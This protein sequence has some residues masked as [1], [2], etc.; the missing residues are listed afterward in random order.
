MCQ[1]VPKGDTRFYTEEATSEQPESVPII[2]GMVTT[3]GAIL[4]APGPSRSADKESARIAAAFQQA[5][6]TKAS[7]IGVSA[8]TCG[9]L[10]KYCEYSPNISRA[11]TN[12]VIRPS[13]HDHAR[14]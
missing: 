11:D 7:E 1:W 13:Q 14:W 9:V 10:Q 5:S 4:A 6:T 8:E 12:P 2:T 3:Y